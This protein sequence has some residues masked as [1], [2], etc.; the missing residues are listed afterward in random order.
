MGLALV[1]E[2]L[3]LNISLNLVF[4]WGY[5]DGKCWEVI[6]IWWWFIVI[7]DQ[8]LRMHW[9]LVPIHQIDQVIIAWIW[10]DC[11][12]TWLLHS[13]TC[14]CLYVDDVLCVSWAD[15]CTLD[16]VTE[17]VH[18]T[19]ISWWD[20]LVWWLK[21]IKHSEHTIL[22]NPFHLFSRGVTTKQGLDSQRMWLDLINLDSLWQV[23]STGSIRVQLCSAGMHFVDE[24]VH[25]DSEVSRVDQRGW[26]FIQHCFVGRWLSWHHT[27]QSVPS[28]DHSFDQTST[29]LILHYMPI[30]FKKLNLVFILFKLIQFSFL[31]Q[32]LWCTSV[33][34]QADRFEPALCQLELWCHFA[35]SLLVQQDR[36]C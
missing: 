32:S 23:E 33:L 34:D 14:L 18:L 3:I 26:A 1:N 4:S 21:A 28:H 24:L 35:L 9:Q 15:I 31:D 20:L 12:V 25:L 10:F 16:V 7:H 19:H 5:V 11:F 22:V 29:R 2:L 17:R 6:I 36:A 8:L 27:M 30:L 13:F